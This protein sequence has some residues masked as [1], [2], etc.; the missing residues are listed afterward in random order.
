M[1]LSEKTL[2]LNLCAQATASV[3]GRFRLLWF[4]LTQ[5][6][7]A[8]AGFDACTRPAGRLLI[9]QFKASDHLLL[10]GDRR[11]L[12]PHLQMQS[13]RRIAANR[14]R[15]VFYAFPLVG[16]TLE[17]AT[18]PDLLPQSW[19][20]DVASLPS[21]GPPTTRSRSVRRNGCHNVYGRPGFASVWSEP[22]DAKLVSFAEFVAKGFPGSDGLDYPSRK[23]KV[24]FGSS[25]CD[26]LRRFSRGAQ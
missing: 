9:F 1:R 21:V 10:G 13:L 11:F 17:F 8:R 3:S 16:N 25:F 14:N 20:L 12:A 4:G 22:I 2:E 26:E 5:K 23:G 24:D 15:S 18:R 6:Q 19:L 7:E